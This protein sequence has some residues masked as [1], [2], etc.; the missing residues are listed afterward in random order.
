MNVQDLRK[1]FIATKIEILPYDKIKISRKEE[2]VIDKMFVSLDSF[3][4]RCTKLGLIGTQINNWT[5]EINASVKKADEDAAATDSLLKMIDDFAEFL[6]YTQ[7][8]INTMRITRDD[9]VGLTHDTGTQLIRWFDF[10]TNLMVTFIK[11]GNIFLEKA[12]EGSG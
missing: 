8:N 2:K 7:H 9:I 4:N 11:K 5:A 10:N 1:I 12:R 6:Q 3:R